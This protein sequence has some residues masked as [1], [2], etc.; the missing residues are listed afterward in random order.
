[1][2]DDAALRGTCLA[3]G[4][5]LRATKRVD[6]PNVGF[7]R[8]ALQAHL[9]GLQGTGFADPHYAELSFLTVVL[10]VKNFARLDEA[11]RKK[12]DIHEGIES[13]LT[14]LQHQLK[15]CIRIE[16]NFGDLP[17]IEC[18]PNQL[19][20]IFMNIL[21]NAAQAIHDGGTIKIKTSREQDRV[22]VE[23]AD[24]GVGIPPEHLSKIFDPGF[25]TNVN[26]ACVPD[27]VYSVSA[28]FKV[29]ALPLLGG[30]R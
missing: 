22:R 27:E 29:A 2:G 4:R 28:G 30:G 17:E 12:V 15:G 7:I 11:E 6:I 19:N 3:L 21:V 24:S 10:H 14:L 25:T 16:R 1:M 8:Q 26:L 13:T 20:Q 18:F 9:T 5:G 23:I